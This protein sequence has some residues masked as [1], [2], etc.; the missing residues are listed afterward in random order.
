MEIK[1]EVR[2]IG[3]GT[4]RTLRKGKQIPAVI[5]G[6]EVENQTLSLVEN[7]VLKISEKVNK[8]KFITVNLG[9]KKVDVLLREVTVHPVSRKP[10]HVDL[11]IPHKSKPGKYDVPIRLIGKAKGLVDGGRVDQLSKSIKV[12]SLSKDLVPELL[13]NMDNMGIGDILRVSDIEFKNSMKCVYSP[14]HP[15]V[16][17]R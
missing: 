13:V 10:V 6:P 16:A 2:K 15:I 11:Y 12:L 8:N 4:S 7:D 5:Y 14:N 3:K 9:D 17:L 1:A